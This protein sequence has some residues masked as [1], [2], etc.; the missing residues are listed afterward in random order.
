MK[1]WVLIIGVLAVVA[2]LLASGCAHVSE[3]TYP[4]ESEVSPVPKKVRLLPDYD[5]KRRLAITWN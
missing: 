1:R 5:D 3:V 4:D 2:F